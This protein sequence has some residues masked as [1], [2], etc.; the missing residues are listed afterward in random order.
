MTE[1][2]RRS[3]SKRRHQNSRVGGGKSRGEAGGELVVVQSSPVQPSPAT[4]LG[5]GEGGRRERMLGE[6]ALGDISVFASI[7]R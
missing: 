3:K 7:F 6:I 2:G 5:G 4:G 1:L